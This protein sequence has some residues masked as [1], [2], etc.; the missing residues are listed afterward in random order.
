MATRKQK[1]KRERRYT[2]A[3]KRAEEHDS[4]FQPTS[5]S[6]PEGVE[7]FRWKKAGI[8]RLDIIPFIAGK[9]NPYADEGEVHWERTYY[10]HRGIGAEENSYA[11][12][13]RTFGKPCPVC[14]HVAKLRADPSSDD[15]LIQGL[16]EKER[17]LF[18]VLDHSDRDKGVQILET[19]HYMGFGEMLDKKIKASDEEDGYANFFHLEDGMTLKVN[20]EEDSFAGRTYMKPTNIEMVRRKEPLDDSLLD[21]VPC[22][23]DIITELSYK[24]LKKIFLQIPAEAENGKAVQQSRP[25]SKPKSSPPPDDEDEDEDD[26]DFEDEDLDEDEEETVVKKP[27]AKKG[28]KQP[29]ADEYGIKK[30][31]KVIHEEHGECEVVHV[32][33]DGTSLRLEDEEGAVHMGVGPDEVELVEEKPKKAGGASSTKKS[34]SPSRSS[35]KEEIDEDEDDFDD[36]DEDLDDDEDEDEEPVA[37]KPAKRVAK[38]K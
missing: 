10:V 17:Q 34:A 12:L 18:L 2:D 27:A 32:S 31:M 33:G 29:T 11:C 15:K 19:S 7:L 28:K 16:R 25:A 1:E 22:L 21:E 35:K 20:V 38:K 6:V 24:E 8:Y 37:K 9:G 4:G 3:K 30:G 14:E 36:E 13:R 23:D 5:F 26:D